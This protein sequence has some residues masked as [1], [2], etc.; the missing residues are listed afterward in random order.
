MVR[1][2][3]GKPRPELDIDLNPGH[4]SPGIRIW[5][6]EVRSGGGRLG[7]DTTCAVGSL[8]PDASFCSERN[9]VKRGS[10]DSPIAHLLSWVATFA[11]CGTAVGSVVCTTE[12]GAAE[13]NSAFVSTRSLA[14]LEDTLICDGEANPP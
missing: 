12:Q 1:R 11:V 5:G 6:R 4:P 7:A 10:E 14:E 2:L 13:Q 8:T 9:R 3:I